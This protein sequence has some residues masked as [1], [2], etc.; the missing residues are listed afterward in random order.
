MHS[1]P[2]GPGLISGSDSPATH[3]SGDTEAFPAAYF[4]IAVMRS[5]SQVPSR[6]PTLPLYKARSPESGT[7]PWGKLWNR[8]AGL[9][10]GRADSAAVR[11]PLMPYYP[12][13]PAPPPQPPTSPTPFLS[14]YHFTSIFYSRTPFISGGA[15]E[16]NLFLRRHKEES[17]F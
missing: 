11:L 4:P 6:P 9:V 8:I 16:K 7:A 5:L 17:V 13:N 10:S 1:E 2:R 15:T 14:P 12:A 3:C